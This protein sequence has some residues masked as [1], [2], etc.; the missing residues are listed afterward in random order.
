[1]MVHILGNHSQVVQQIY[2]TLVRVSNVTL[3]HSISYN[4]AVSPS[5]PAICTPEWHTGR[6]ALQ[7]LPQG[8][9]TSEAT[10]RVPQ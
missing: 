10:R 4:Y 8:E 5:L 3:Y 2:N 1:M 6:S 7:S 9:L